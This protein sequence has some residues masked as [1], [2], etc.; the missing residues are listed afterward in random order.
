MTSTLSKPDG[1]WSVQIE[2]LSGPTAVESAWSDLEKRANPSF[3]QSW[4]WIGAWLLTF[5]DDAGLLFLRVRFQER[6]VGLSVLGRN[7]V[8]ANRLF[9]SKALLV[10]EAGVPEH[11]AITVEHSGMLIEAGLEQEVL[12]RAL[13]HLQDV[14]WN[15]DELFVSGVEE[16]RASDYEKAAADA[17][18][19]YS[20][21]SEHPYYYVDLLALGSHDESYLQTLSRNT[22]YQIR[23]AMRMYEARGTLAIQMADSLDVALEWFERLR[24]LHQSHWTGRGEVGAFPNA[25]VTEFHE[26]LIR[27]CFPR[28]Q[29][30]MVCVTVGAQPVGYLYNFV[31]DGVVSNYQTAFVYEQDGRY[32]P[33]LVSHALTIQANAANGHKIYDLLMGDQQFK[34]SLAKQCETMVWLVLGNAS[35]RMTVRNKIRQLWEWLERR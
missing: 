29:V 5:P 32:K 24:E 18:M 26:A 3:F 14:Q 4:G 17:G 2:E 22:R 25:R 34:R 23:R 16:Q 8:S 27:E 9:R 12:P 19:F 15:W 10:S 28:G 20:V 33:G 21:R 13:K 11:D 30:Q 1:A 6:D 31:L 35:L 7:V